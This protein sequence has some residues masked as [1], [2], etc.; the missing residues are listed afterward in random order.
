MNSVSHGA[1][2]RPY[3]SGDKPK[4]WEQAGLSTTRVAQSAAWRHTFLIVRRSCNRGNVKPLSQGVGIPHS[5][6][7]PWLDI[8]KRSVE[9]LGRKEQDSLL[10]FPGWW[11]KKQLRGKVRIPALMLCDPGRAIGSL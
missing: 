1:I 7:L 5:Q 2:V 6:L 10:S 4:D 8:S 3:K 9:D 11:V